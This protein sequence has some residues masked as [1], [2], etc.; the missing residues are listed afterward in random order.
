MVAGVVGAVV[1][2][3]LGLGLGVGLGFAAQP[4]ARTEIASTRITRVYGVMMPARNIRKVG[5]EGEVRIDT[6]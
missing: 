6:T 3:G 2:A 5:G 1:A 4:I